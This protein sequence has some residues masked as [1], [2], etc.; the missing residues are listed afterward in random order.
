MS[1]WLSDFFKKHKKIFLIHLI[2]IGILVI[3]FVLCRYAFF[4]LRGMNEWPFTLLLFG[5]AA[6]LLSLLARKKCAPWF[7]SAGYFIGFWIAVIF[8]THGFDPGGGKTDNFWGIWMVAFFACIL[9]GIFFE[10]GLK[11]WKLLKKR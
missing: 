10:V 11:W 9:V 3:S 4:G 8:H 2:S 6:L 5:L 7:I 1:K